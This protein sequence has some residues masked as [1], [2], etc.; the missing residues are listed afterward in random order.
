M[1]HLQYCFESAPPRGVCARAARPTHVALRR[2][3]RAERGARHE[4]AV[5]A[6]ALGVPAVVDVDK[7]A[8]VAEVGSRSPI[9][10]RRSALALTSSSLQQKAFQLLQP[11]GGLRGLARA[12]VAAAHGRAHKPHIALGDAEFGH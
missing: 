4:L 8:G 10:T 2:Y 11:I 5:R 12:E 3:A 6:A 7:A 1:P 9:D